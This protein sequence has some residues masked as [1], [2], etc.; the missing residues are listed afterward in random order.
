MKFL[1]TSDLHLGIKLM[2]VDLIEDQEYIL[3]EIVDIAKKEKVDAVLLSG[4]VYDVSVPRVEAIGLLNEF[5]TK[6]NEEKINVFIIS[7]NHDQAERLSFANQIL[8]KSGV[9]IS[10][11]YKKDNKPIIMKDKYGDVYIYLLPYI[12]PINIRTEFVIDDNM[13]YDEAV[14]KAI[15]NYSINKNERNVLLAHQFIT[16]SIISESET[17][18]VGNTDQVSS[19]NFDSF[20]YVALGHLHTPQIIKK[21]ENMRYSGSPLKLSFSEVNKDKVCVIVDLKEKGNIEIKE[22]QLKPLHDMAILNGTYSE[23]VDSKE[24][25]SKYRDAY[26]RIELKD[27]KEI[28]YV[29]DRLRAVY[30]NV[31]EVE[32][33]R[34]TKQQK[35]LETNINEIK[36][37]SDLDLVNMFFKEQ[38]NKELNSKQTKIIKNALE[39]LEDM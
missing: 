6:L 24:L 34:K 12:K 3:N 9:Y 7:G 15:E 4:D 5:L 23:L 17:I 19:R 8:K 22:V 32:Y 36:S 1:H 14:K 11:R 13:A 18:Q 38:L 21:N 16:G 27:K 2:D 10:E 33:E 37:L 35:E 30:N 28:P 39:E 25:K 26:L 31:L 20:D 29:K